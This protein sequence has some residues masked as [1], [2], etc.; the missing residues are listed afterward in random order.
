MHMNAIDAADGLARDSR[1]VV[2]TDVIVVAIGQIQDIQPKGDVV[3]YL[4][5]HSKFVDRLKEERTLLFSISGADPMYRT[6]TEPD[7]GP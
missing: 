3:G 6:P 1:G 7:Q 5:G 4:P 2:V